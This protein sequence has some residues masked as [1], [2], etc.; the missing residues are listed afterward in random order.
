MTA[1]RKPRLKLSRQEAAALCPIL[2][3]R[4]RELSTRGPSGPIRH[5]IPP[6]ECVP[7]PSDLPLRAWARFFALAVIQ[8]HSRYQRNALNHGAASAWCLLS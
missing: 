6:P 7:L 3:R 2:A 4:A 5:A 8:N 1:K